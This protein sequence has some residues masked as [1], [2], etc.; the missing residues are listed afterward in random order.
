M[1]R[2][3]FRVSIRL[4]A[5]WRFSFVKYRPLIFMCPRSFSLLMPMT[6]VQENGTQKP[7]PE[8][9]FWFMEHVSCDLV[10]N[11]SGISSCYQFKTC[12]ILL[13]VLVSTASSDWSL[14]LS[15]FFV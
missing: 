5:I 1:V 4:S 15:N 2:I 3:S 13:P 8:K 14:L 7:V 12:S 11:F 10:L 9:W 6:D